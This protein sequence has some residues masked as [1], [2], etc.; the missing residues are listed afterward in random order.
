[1]SEST[2]CDGKSARSALLNTMMCRLPLISS[3]STG[4]ADENGI[5]QGRDS[6]N[7]AQ[8]SDGDSHSGIPNLQDDLRLLDSRLKVL[9]RARHVTRKPAQ[10]GPR[11]T[12]AVAS[13]SAPV[14]ARAL[15]CKLRGLGE[16]ACTGRSSCGRRRGSSSG[17]LAIALQRRQRPQRACSTHEDNGTSR[18]PATHGCGARIVSKQGALHVRPARMCRQIVQ[19]RLLSA[20]SRC[21]QRFLDAVD[22]QRDNKVHAGRRI[23]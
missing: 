2:F 4:L 15:L 20:A 7:A 9:H 17:K 21:N 19:Q 8:A 11:S 22:K 3:N 1:M 12:K 14:D 13:E 5:W 18:S 6:W 10:Q 16:G 23:S